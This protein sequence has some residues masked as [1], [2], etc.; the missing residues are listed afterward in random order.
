MDKLL[1]RFSSTQ[2]I[3]QI[4]NGD[5]STAKDGRSALYFRRNTNYVMY[6]H[7]HVFIKLT[8]GL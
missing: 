3:K 6:G 2:V 4:F 8:I 1:H 5:P 7:D